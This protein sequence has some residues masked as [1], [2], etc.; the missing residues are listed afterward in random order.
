VEQNFARTFRPSYR[1]T[2]L[3]KDYCS[4]RSAAIELMKDALSTTVGGKARIR[5][6]SDPSGAGG[7]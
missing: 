6:S 4:A 2:F 1:C 5:R 3:P 7:P